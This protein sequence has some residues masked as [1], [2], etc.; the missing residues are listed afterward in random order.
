MTPE[1]EGTATPLQST[2]TSDAPPQ[3][4]AVVPAETPLP[5]GVVGTTVY[6]RLSRGRGPG[7]VRD[8][9]GNGIDYEPPPLPGNLPVWTRTG[10]QQFETTWPTG[11]DPA[12]VASLTD[13]GVR[14]LE[15]FRTELEQV[16]S[17]SADSPLRQMRLRE[18]DAF[19]CRLLDLVVCLHAGGCGLGLLN[20]QAILLA[21]KGADLT[22]LLPDL[23]FRRAPTFG[24]L[25]HWL[26]EE[27]PFVTQWR[28]LWDEGKLADLQRGGDPLADPQPD[29]RKLARLLAWLLRGRVLRR[30]PTRDEDPST[31]AAVWNLLD[32]A[33]AGRLNSVRDFRQRL[34]EP[35]EPFD[36]DDPD[37]VSLSD[38]FL[39]DPFE[40]EQTG[41]QG[42][43]LARSV[44]AAVVV[45]GLGAVVGTA[46]LTH[47]PLIGAHPVEVA[48]IF[49]ANP[50][51]ELPTDS[52]LRGPLQMFQQAQTAEERYRALVLIC[53]ARASYDERESQ[54]E[55]L[56]REKARLDFVR[57]QDFRLDELRLEAEQQVHLL[58][59]CL[60][61]AE[62]IQRW[63]R[64]VHTYPAHASLMEK[65]DQCL[66]TCQQWIDRQ[67]AVY[68]G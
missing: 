55:A 32:D 14:T 36:R 7:L 11:P 46:V 18:L 13:L 33:E 16:R 21:G 8:K 37:R 63:L 6:C 28:N 17:Q 51:A 3:P 56:Y 12:E 29:L 25:P 5:W 44:W 54:L 68:G 66:E 53:Q 57:E 20:P 42:S 4:S 49:P 65:E 22:V 1:W 10:P 64:D 9:V 62:T 50:T 43:L 41:G 67:Y 47:R 59:E 48:A 27:G 23:G 30:I 26:I 15:Q 40:K 34:R 24:V 2:S 52:R 38:D 60:F 39:P 35:E 58:S 31:Y 45:V 61:R 19:A